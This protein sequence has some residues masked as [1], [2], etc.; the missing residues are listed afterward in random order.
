MVL[1]VE[2]ISL[3]EPSDDPEK[4]SATL[5]VTPANDSCYNDDYCSSEYFCKKNKGNCNGI[6]TCVEMPG[7]CT[8]EYVPVC[9]CDGI[10]YGNKCEASRAGISI[11]HDEQCCS[12]IQCYMYCVNGFKVDENGCDICECK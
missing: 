5:L 2:L 7:A 12:P 3:S 10:T 1:N 8:K 4:Y 6:G 11:E 9:G